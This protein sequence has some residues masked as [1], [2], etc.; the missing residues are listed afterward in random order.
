ME[1][2]STNHPGRRITD[3]PKWQQEMTTRHPGHMNEMDLM[4]ECAALNQSLM[5][6]REFVAALDYVV[7]IWLRTHDELPKWW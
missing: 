1:Y 4:G 6:H 2:T 3:K 5:P 7:K